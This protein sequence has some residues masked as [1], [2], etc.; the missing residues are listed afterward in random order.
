MAP[1]YTVAAPN[2]GVTLNGQANLKIEIGMAAEWFQQAD[3]QG[4]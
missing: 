1:G 2:A 3:Q 4:S